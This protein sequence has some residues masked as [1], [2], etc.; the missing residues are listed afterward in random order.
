[1]RAVQVI[2]GLLIALSGLWVIAMPLAF[3]SLID[4]LTQDDIWWSRYRDNLVRGG[5]VPMVGMGLFLVVVGGCM[6]KGEP[7]GRVDPSERY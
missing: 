2:G 6:M 1:M 7:G 3:A 4:P 5:R